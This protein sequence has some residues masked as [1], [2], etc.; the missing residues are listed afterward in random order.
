MTQRPGRS[1]LRPRGAQ[2]LLD[3]WTD[4][5]DRG[6]F[7]VRADAATRRRLAIGVL[8]GSLVFALVVQSAFLAR[9]TWM[10]GDLAY[11]RGVA[12]GMQ[13]GMLQGEG[14]FAG[15]LSYYGGLFPLGLAFASLVSGAT[16]D[17]I[18]SVT[19]WIGTLMLPLAFAVLGR[20]L[21]PT[22]LLAVALLVLVGTVATPLTTQW[23]ALWVESVLPSG[24]SFWPLYPRDI[25]L[26][27]MCAGLWAV[28]SER[29]AARTIGLGVIGGLCLLFH[30]QMSLL[31][32]WFLLV[33]VAGRAVAARRLEPLA[34]LAVAGVVG[35]LVAAW[36][37]VPRLLALRESGALLIA[38]YAGR[39]EFRPGPAE[40][41][42]AF[43]VAGLLAVVGVALF[44]IGRSRGTAERLFAAWLAAFLPLVVISRLAPH[45]ELFTER[46]VWLVLSIGIVGFA[47]CALVH[48]ARRAPATLAV[49]LSIAIVVVPSLPGNVASVTRVRNAT[50]VAWRPGN[51]G[52]ARELDV[53]AW[54]RA[55]TTLN[56]LVRRDGRATILTYDAF[57]AYAWSF[58]GAQI[59]ST[60]TPGPFKL[61]F[62]PERLTGLG[63]LERGRRLQSAFDGGA[64]GICALATSS[65][66]GRLLLASRSGLVGFYDRSFAAPYRVEPA[67]RPGAGLLREVSP[68]V[69]YEDLN[70]LDRLNLAPRAGVDVPWQAP[71]IEVVGILVGADALPGGTLL[72]MTTGSGTQVVEGRSG[73]GIGWVYL[74]VG[75]VEGGIRLEALAPIELYEIRGYAAW[76]GTGVVPPDGQFVIEPA[77]LCGR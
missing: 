60:W 39:I 29:R 45:V 42:I 1:T 17:A 27:L 58:S 66:Y 70:G 63:Y 4:R 31:L 28:T 19:S 73:T 41:V 23:D 20:R 30:A 13:G 46:R 53:P 25:A 35:L 8:G 43:G 72:S 34:E 40:F 2:W 54:R 65:G 51:A 3:R 59:E 50:S 55:M 33:F 5:L 44:V 6:R 71:E 48:L 61:G 14:P 9:S 16:F 11:H 22:D 15:L 18:L 69:V 52:M 12:Y 67:E 24:S 57:G 26:A 68:G 74:D 47:A 77:H 56:S 21:W 32:A 75:G 62:D 7:A 76:P 64:A 36:W 37:W 49:A 10:L 38:D